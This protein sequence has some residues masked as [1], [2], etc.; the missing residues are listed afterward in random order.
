MDD[1]SVANTVLDL[2]IVADILQYLRGD[3]LLIPHS[4][5]AHVVLE[6]LHQARMTVC[7]QC[8][9][10]GV[11]EKPLSHVCEGAFG[12]LVHVAG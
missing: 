8:V 4:S 9:D 10:V 12:Y 11:F 3:H 1:V 2:E 7:K 5:L 6:V